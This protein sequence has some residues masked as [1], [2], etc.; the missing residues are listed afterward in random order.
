MFL[1]F[2]QVLNSILNPNL[3]LGEGV[4]DP[5]DETAEIKDDAAAAVPQGNNLFFLRAATLYLRYVV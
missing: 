4:Y 3:P 5:A 2:R 1:F